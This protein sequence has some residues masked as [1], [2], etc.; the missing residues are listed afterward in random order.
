MSMLSKAL[1]CAALADSQIP[2]SINY[3]DGNGDV[4]RR[5][6]QLQHAQRQIHRGARQY[7]RLSLD[8]VPD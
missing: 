5:G 7:Q 8:G 4:L 3:H 2:H 1:Q 6:Q